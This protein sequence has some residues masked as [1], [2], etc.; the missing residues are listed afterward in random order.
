VSENPVSLTAYWTLAARY[1]DAAAERPVAGDA[2]AERLM[3]ERA[4]EV[5]ELFRP[6]E[7]PT[8]SLPVRHR[9]IDER[10]AAELERDRSLRVFVIGCGF[11]ARAFRLHGGRWVEV[12]EPGLLEFK[13][14]RLPVF[15]CENELVRVPI[16]FGAEPLAEKLA[17]YASE[18]RVVVVL[19]GIMVYL[20]DD[21]RRELLMTLIR[22]FPRHAVLCDLLNRRFVALYSRALS[23]Q[24]RELGADFAPP[25]N[26]PEALFHELGYRTAGRDSI[27]LRATQLGAKSAPPA[28][29]VRVLPALR[30]GYCVW[31]FEYGAAAKPTP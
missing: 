3:D 8:A 18:E 14:T 23:K 7:R 21:Q 25:S 5:A 19:E 13:E 15:E 22:L 10:L 26:H 1:E 9:L 20:R 16:R 29:A 27:W 24:V 6:L 12:D 11:D 4:R 28:W 17:P 2:F 30:N 31:A